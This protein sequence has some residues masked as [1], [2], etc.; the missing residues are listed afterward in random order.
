MWV[1][2]H[3]QQPC[4]HIGVTTKGPLDTGPEL[5]NLDDLKNSDHHWY[6]TIDKYRTKKEDKGHQGSLP[7]DLDS[8]QGQTVGCWV[9]ESGEFGFCCRESD[10]GDV[11][12]E[13]LPT[14][15][16]LWGFVAFQGK[17]EV[18]ANYKVV[19]PKGEAVAV[20][21]QWFLL[22]VW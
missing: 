11:M 3:L 21:F 6:A 15:K 20:V 9:S 22:V 14:D 8:S 7:W 19:L 12:G 4:L 5:I 1:F 16:P 13:G 18:E 2:V 17:W 10:V